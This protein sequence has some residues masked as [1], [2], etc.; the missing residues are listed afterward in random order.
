MPTTTDTFDL[1]AYG[2]T[3]RCRGQVSEGKRTEFKT[4]APPKTQHLEH[5]VGLGLTTGIATGT[6]RRNGNWTVVYTNRRIGPG[7]TG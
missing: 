2:V 3:L 6:S 4:E 7:W 1:L 5:R